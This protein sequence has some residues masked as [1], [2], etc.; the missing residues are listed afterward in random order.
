VRG[1]WPAALRAV[2]WDA[3]AFAFL[4]FVALQF[5][6]IAVVGAE[7]ATPQRIRHA[8]KSS[9]HVLAGRL[10]CR[11]RERNDHSVFKVCARRK[12][13]L[14]GKAVI[15]IDGVLTTGTTVEA[16]TRALRVDIVAKLMR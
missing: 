5:K 2:S 13:S 9:Q 3:G 14:K 12:V 11:T 6:L 15:L 16:C 4:V 8:N 1:R 7:A 10:S